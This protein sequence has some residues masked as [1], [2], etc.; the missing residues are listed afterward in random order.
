MSVHA[1]KEMAED[2]LDNHRYRVRHLE[3][4]TSSN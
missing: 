3:W 4:A 1:M 2:N